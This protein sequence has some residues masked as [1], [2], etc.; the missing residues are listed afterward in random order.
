LLYQRQNDLIK[1]T[2]YSEQAV[3]IALHE[4]NMVVE[5]QILKQKTSQYSRAFEQLVA[6]YA[7]RHYSEKALA[8]SEAY[9]AGTVRVHTMSPKEK[10]SYQRT[11]A[12]KA[13]RAGY[14]Q[15]LGGSEAALEIAP[16]N[17]KSVLPRIDPLRKY[18][19][20]K[21]M[22]LVSLN[23]SQGF[24]TVLILGRKKLFG[25]G[26]ATLQWR[27]DPSFVKDVERYI[28]LDPSPFREYRLRQ[29]CD[30]CWRAL[31]EPM[32]SYFREHGI[33]TVGLVAPSLIGQVPFEGFERPDS[34]EP[35]ITK[36]VNFFYLPSLR[37]GSDLVSHVQGLR[38]RKLLIVG[39]ADDDLP[40]TIQEV[41]TLKALF[42]SR[43]VV[44]D[45]RGMSKLEVTKRI[46]EP[47]DYVHFTCHGSF[48]PAVPLD[49]ALHLVRDP[50]N[51]NQRITA[52][53]LL[54]MKFPNTPIVTMSACSTA[55]VG[56]DSSNGY[57]GLI[58]SLLQGGARCVIGSRWP[59]YDDTASI[60]MTSLYAR[61]VS[62]TDSPFDCF[63]ATQHDRTKL[64]ALEDWAAFAYVGLP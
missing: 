33:T 28:D 61:L 10:A 39:Y 30:I 17:L 21:N 41:E 4:I 27:I 12:E 11:A 55:L 45:T 34:D 40:F 2:Q 31:L 14:K 42:K 56:L 37:V 6:L 8:V 52:R 19:R 22:A 13:V 54:G 38:A 58:G 9:R 18:L 16:L 35:N 43:V 47:Y 36:A 48:N 60:F 64:K 51:D 50:Q 25:N 57:A 44:L 23:I 53:D 62:A 63:V 20:D 32:Q 1:A 59:V 46:Q 26:L 5:E 49:S 7:T 15:L 24:T 29:I 3:A